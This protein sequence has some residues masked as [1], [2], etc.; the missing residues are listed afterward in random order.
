LGASPGS[1]RPLASLSLDL[2]NEWAY[3]KVMGDDRWKARPSYLPEFVPAILESLDRL[4]LRITFCVVGADLERGPDRDAISQIVSAGHE[5]A[6]HSDE[7]EPWLSR[8][9]ED[10][11]EKD[12][13][14]AEIA[15]Q[16]LTG[17]R[18]L[19][20][21]A[22][23]Y[24]CSNSLLRILAKRGYEY[25]A[26]ILPSWI[27]PL[28]RAWFYRRTSLTREE[29]KTRSLLFGRWD[30]AFL[31]AGPFRWDLESDCS[32]L[33]IPVTAVPLLRTPMHMTYVSLFSTYSKRATRAYFKAALRLCAWRRITPSFLLHPLDLW[34]GD[35][36]PRL[37]RLAG[38]SISSQEKSQLMQRTLLILGD[39]FQIVPM[40][41][42][43]RA[44]RARED[45][46]HRISHSA[47]IP[48]GV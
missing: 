16:S 33:E 20:Y 41:V 46:P 42:H 10:A 5:I 24:A 19:G 13:A 14:S 30:D 8:S 29:R 31:P 47:S 39:R 28:A 37:R 23:G 1:D 6:S 9:G 45:L 25:D 34:G 40:C 27:S 11:L 44:L 17:R 15:I 26:S 2:D 12:I 32:M 21:R 3:L 4:G 38:M 43:A 35:R 48:V 7:H 18:P 22:P 36:I